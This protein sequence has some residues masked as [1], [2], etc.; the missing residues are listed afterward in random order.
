M[1][2]DFPVFSNDTKSK[3]IAF[4]IPYKWRDSCVHDLISWEACRK[5]NSIFGFYQCSDMK[6][7]WETCQNAREKKILNQPGFRQVPEE[8][9]RLSF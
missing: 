6:K 2:E 1:E 9:R 8:K 4:S 5:E 7:A 3:I